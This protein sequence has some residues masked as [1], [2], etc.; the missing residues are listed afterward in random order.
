MSSGERVRLLI[1]R[2]FLA[3]AVVLVLD[4]IA[5]VLDEE[6]RREVRRAL[7]E[8]SNL[9]VIEATVDTPLLQNPTKRI[10]IES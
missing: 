5:G 4:D 7:E 6:N 2:A 10:E 8:R 3:N 1:A 9:A